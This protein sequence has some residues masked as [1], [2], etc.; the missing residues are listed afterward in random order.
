MAKKKWPHLLT[1]IMV[2]NLGIFKSLAYLKNLTYTSPLYYLMTLKIL[3]ATIGLC[4]LQLFFGS[5]DL[6]AQNFQPQTQISFTSKN[7]ELEGATRYYLYHRFDPNRSQFGHE[8]L[9]YDPFVNSIEFYSRDELTFNLLSNKRWLYEGS[10]FLH[11]NRRKESPT[12]NDRE[13]GLGDLILGGHYLLYDSDLFATD[14]NRRIQSWIGGF[15]KLPIGTF[16]RFNKDAELEPQFQAGT[17]STDYFIKTNNLIFINKIIFEVRGEYRIN[18]K[19]KY[20]YQFGNRIEAEA[21][22]WYQLLKPLQIGGTFLYENFQS[23]IMN[24]REILNLL[25]AGED[26]GLERFVFAPQL[27]L[28]LS[29]WQLNG[30]YRLLLSEKLQGQQLDYQ[31]GWEVR[32]RYFF[33]KN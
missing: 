20:G 23:D 4:L 22:V 3:F 2:G 31:Y 8:H 32:L 15:I 13:L 6:Y 29:N 10:I 16:D 5:N 26:T 7:Y 19:N 17:G 24:D 11:K 33:G 14:K 30:N 9:I 18:G 27:R 28:D 1:H 25:N 21:T 12:H